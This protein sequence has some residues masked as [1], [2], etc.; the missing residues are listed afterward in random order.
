MSKRVRRKSNLDLE[1]EELLYEGRMTKPDGTV[2]SWKA[3]WWL[4][5]KKSPPQKQWAVEKEDLEDLYE[6]IND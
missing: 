1:A 4:I 3:G 5:T 2:I 6:E